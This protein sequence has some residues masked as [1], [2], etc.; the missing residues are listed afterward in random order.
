MPCCASS[1]ATMPACDAQ[2]PWKR[3]VQA[4]SV[5]NSSRPA[6]WLHATPSA[7]VTWAASSPSS[8]A[9]VAAAPSAPVVPVGWN[10]R[11]LVTAGWS[12]A[13]T[14]Q[15]TS[16]PATTAVRKRFPLAPRSSAN[17]KAGEKTKDSLWIEPGRN[18]SSSSMLCAAIPFASAAQVAC[19]GSGRPNSVAPPG[20]GR[21][22]ASPR[23]GRL[24]SSVEACRAM[25]M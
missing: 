8:V 7:T 19:T 9:A 21:A 13:A 20:I 16:N 2:P 4:P 23:T 17:A 24:E 18:V 10:P 22:A 15:A 6:A 14:R 3:F 1:A 5:T 12:A 11:P 25:A